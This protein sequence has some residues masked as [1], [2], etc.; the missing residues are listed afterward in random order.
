MELARLGG[1]TAVVLREATR[2]AGVSHN[3]AYRHFSDR[4]ALLDAVCSAAMAQLAEA[5]RAEQAAVAPDLDAAGTAQA[6]LRA[7]GVGYLRYAQNEPGLCRTAFSAANGHVD[8]PAVGTVAPAVR[9]GE[10]VGPLVILKAALDDAVA[11]GV[12]TPAR[13]PDAEVMAWSAVHGLA[14]LVIDGPL[15]ALDRREVDRLG[16]R[17]L[18][19]LDAGL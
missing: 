13:C 3:A 15:R 6:R 7:V 5:M 18:D 4:H 2:R 14:M 9:I 10:D 19:V 12:L 8:E 11:T 1:P 16:Q 17:L